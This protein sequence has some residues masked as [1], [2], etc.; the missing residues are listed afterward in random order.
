MLRKFLFIIFCLTVVSCEEKVEKDFKAFSDDFVK[1]YVHLFPDET[2]LSK[3]NE[4]L[5][6]LALPTPEYFD[7][8]R[9]FHHRFSSELK[10]FDTRNSALPYVK[11]ARKI[12]HILNNVNGFLSDYPQ[13]PV[14]FNVLHG[15][16]RILET[17]YAPDGYRL[18]TIFG[19]LAHVPAFY[20][21]AKIQLT[22]SNR[23]LDD[24]AVEQQIQTFVFF[25]QT[26]PNFLN[27]HNLMTPQYTARIL[28]AKLAVK[29]YVA[30]VESFRVN[31]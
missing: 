20:E 3:E 30:F 1:G 5:V 2:P 22:K 10:Q 14:R 4:N 17:N 18:Q 9:Q 31:N 15:F 24:A 11:D 25:D 19:K 7:S 23:A 26:L 6:L 27:S 28:S 16:K 13:N 29:D 21:A 8:V 12:E